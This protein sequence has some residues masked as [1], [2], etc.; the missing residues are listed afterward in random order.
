MGEDLE[1]R[2]R[3][4]ED[5]RATLARIEALQGQVALEQRHLAEVRL[6]QSMLSGY[7]GVTPALRP[8]AEV[9]ADVPAPASTAGEAVA[10]DAETEAWLSAAQAEEL[11]R[12]NRLFG[13]NAAN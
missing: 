8:I 5:E 10:G 6:F 2:E 1:L 11:E 13:L 3:A 9:P 4:A 12:L 7:V